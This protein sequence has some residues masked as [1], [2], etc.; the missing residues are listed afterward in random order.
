MQAIPY[1]RSNLREA[2]LDRAAAAIEETG[3]DGISLRQIAR[4]LGVSHAAP[5]R[6]FP[7][8]QTLRTA[9]VRHGLAELGDQLAAATT[10]PGAD[11]GTRLTA[12]AAAFVGY[13]AAH[14]ALTSLVLATTSDDS[15]E[16][17]E[18]NEIKQR[19]FR[20]AI[21]L[22]DDAHREGTVV[23][24]PDRVA[25]AILAVIQGLATMVAGGSIGDRPAD[26]VV[27]GTVDVLLHGLL[28]RP[29]PPAK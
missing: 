10:D 29:K 21:A 3:F 11:F 6:Y 8:R 9:L 14:P 24:D 13:A 15:A 27:T 12:F 4:D 1:R 18:L 23:G 20:A 7:D 28:P 16:G 2:V 22:L 26:T 17:D 25:M 5:N 19:T